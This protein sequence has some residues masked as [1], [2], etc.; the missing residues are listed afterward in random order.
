MRQTAVVIQK[1]IVISNQDF[2]LVHVLTL[3]TFLMAAMMRLAALWCLGDLGSC[4][5]RF[6]G[7][8]FCLSSSSYVQTINHILFFIFHWQVLPIVDPAGWDIDFVQISLKIFYIEY[9]PAYKMLK[10]LV[11]YQKL[12]TYWPAYN[13]FN[14]SSW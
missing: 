6:N 3:T 9:M 13:N 1:L 11:L 12:D 10:K 4:S 14:S 7:V 2:A 5:H 8:R